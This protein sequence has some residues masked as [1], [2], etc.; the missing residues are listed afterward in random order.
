MTNTNDLGF[1]ILSLVVFLPAVGAIILAFMRGQ[2][3]AARIFALGWSTLV[4]AVSLPILFNFKHDAAGLQFYEYFNWIPDWGVR[5]ELGLDGISLWLVLLTTFVTP[6]AIWSAWNVEEKTNNFLML[7]LLQ[8]TG[9]LGVFLAQDLFLFYIFWEFTLIP[10]Y[11]LIGMWGG[12]RRIYATV[13]FFLYTFAASVFML[14]GI[15]ALGLL[16]YKYLAQQGLPTDTAF[17]VQTLM[18]NI[19]QFGLSDTE[20]K[21]LFLSFFVAFAVKV[22]LWPVHTWLPDAHVE[23]PTAGSVILAAVLLKMGGYGMIR[24]CVQLFP[25]IAQEWA[26]P[27][28]LLA[29]IGIIYGAVLSYAQSDIKKL[30]AYSSVSHMGFIVLGIFALNEVGLQGAVLQM[31]NHGLSTGALFLLIGMVYERT[32][33]RELADYG[34][35]W[36][37][38]PVFVYFLLF[39]TMASVGLPGLNGFVG[40]FLIMLGAFDSPIGWTFTAFAAVGVILAAVYL[41]KMFQGIASG[42]FSERR[43]PH[44]SDLTRREVAILLPLCI[45][46]LVIGLYS[47]YFTRPME[48]TIKALEAFVANAAPLIAGQ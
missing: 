23:A 28:A 46:M 1:T 38:V 5:Y 8:E 24:F 3:G 36:K 2:R 33:T 11:F 14:I 29:V 43:T 40:E 10:M 41:L 12:K 27:I 45:L 22:P 25:Q 20:L 30:V 4:F 7:I 32:H 47:S 48:T 15:I 34:G 37:V 42:P 26:R 44:L 21:L 31:I 19:N 18:A 13:K 35:L 16:N 6:L 17:Q 39:A 9:M